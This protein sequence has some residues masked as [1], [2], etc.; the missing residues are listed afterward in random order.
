MLVARERCTIGRGIG[1]EG[2]HSLH[3]RGSGLS[4]RRSYN[5]STAG[6]EDEDE[7]EE[8]E[9]EDVVDLIAGSER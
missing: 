4:M 3:S 2:S 9:E 6:D 7:E 8:E 5:S 1:G